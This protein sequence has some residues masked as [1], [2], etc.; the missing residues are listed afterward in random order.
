MV[1]S[2]ARVNPLSTIDVEEKIAKN[3]RKIAERFL[4]TLDGLIQAGTKDEAKAMIES[5]GGIFSGLVPDKL[6]EIKQALLDYLDAQTLPSATTDNGVIGAHDTNLPIEPTPE[7]DNS[8]NEIN[9]G[10]MFQS[11]QDVLAVATNV[12]IGASS[13]DFMTK[14]NRVPNEI[15]D[16]NTELIKALAIRAVAKNV[17]QP[18]YDR[19][20]KQRTDPYISSKHGREYLAIAKSLEDTFFSWSRDMMSGKDIQSGERTKDI[21]YTSSDTQ[22]NKK[23]DQ[24]I[25][26]VANI[27]VE[28]KPFINFEV[29]EYGVKV[30]LR[31]FVIDYE[32]STVRPASK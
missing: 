27:S 5:S 32:N 23:N 10:G 14:Q 8:V 25:Q 15:N 17:L 4:Q 31:N 30:T 28:L 2:E 26:L 7:I 3:F 1:S 19:C 20:K 21:S 6:E 9:F 18:L 16:E 11:A 22:D 24:V 29:S 12:G 13:R